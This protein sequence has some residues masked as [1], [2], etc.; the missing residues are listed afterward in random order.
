MTNNM[1]YCVEAGDNTLEK[2]LI[3]KKITVQLEIPIEIYFKTLLASLNSQKNFKCRLEEIVENNSD[4]NIFRSCIHFFLISDEEQKDLGL[5]YKQLKS[6]IYMFESETNG[7]MTG[8]S[9]KEKYFLKTVEYLK[10]IP[11]ELAIHIGIKVKEILDA[12]NIKNVYDFLEKKEEL[13]LKY[14]ER[15]IEAVYVALDRYAIVRMLNFAHEE[16]SKKTHEKDL[17]EQ[18]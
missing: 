16:F 7:W 2:D 9:A 17:N 11:V 15:T 6:F 4:Y 13:E 3:N 14:N 12:E 8:F 10:K 5:T 18:S 1:D